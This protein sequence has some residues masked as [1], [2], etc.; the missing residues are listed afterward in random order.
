MLL[1]AL[2]EGIQ[3]RRRPG[4]LARRHRQTGRVLGLARRIVE[5]RSASGVLI[6]LGKEWT[7]RLGRVGVL[8]VS[9]KISAE[10]RSHLAA[11][12]VLVVLTH[13]ILDPP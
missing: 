10:D 1:A 12:P 6:D 7:D 13:L 4:R 2:P 9:K 3:A 8:A 5:D 11:L